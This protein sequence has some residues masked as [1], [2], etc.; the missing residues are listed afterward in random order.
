MQR[1]IFVACALVPL[2]SFG[3]ETH[4]EVVARERTGTGGT[5]GGGGAPGD[6][7]APGNGAAPGD[8]AAGASAA[9]ATGGAASSAR[10]TL[11]APA[12]VAILN[13]P[14]AKDQ[15]PSLT[16]DM[17][18]IFFFSD[19]DGNADI[20]TSVRSAIDSEWTQPMPVSELNSQEIEQNPEIS[21]DGLTI[22]F[23]SRREPIGIYFSERPGRTQPFGEPE[24][25]AINSGS[26]PDSFPIAPSVDTSTLRMALSI[27]AA[28]TRDLY[29]VVRPSITG[30]WGE[31]AFLLGVNSD[32]VDST[33]F[34]VGD[35]REMLFSSGRAGN[36]DLFWAYR[37]SPG[38]P[39]TRVEPLA[40]LN[41]PVAFETHP[42]L[43]S[44]RRW[45]YFGSDRGGNT[46]IYVSEVIE[47]Q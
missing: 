11:T 1:V 17:L 46:D 43:T 44:D 15:D 13:D 14:N 40:E 28:T 16:G 9:P 6:G 2:C 22:W 19:R 5:S 35:G 24:F 26:D 47:E 45:L 36:G 21:N 25:I 32:N 27:G 38:L 10:P 34:L 8:G 37:D 23:Y 30:T 18:E 39:F 29:E 12:P 33:P 4:S 42:H 20:W 31:P 7:A 41:D 3:C